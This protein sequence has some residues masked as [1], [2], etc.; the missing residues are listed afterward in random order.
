LNSFYGG[1]LLVFGKL[2]PSSVHHFSD[3]IGGFPVFG[4][5]GF[6]AHK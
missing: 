4:V 5:F 1:F 2:L 3:L 6:G